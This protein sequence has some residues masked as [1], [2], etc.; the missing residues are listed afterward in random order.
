MT[1]KSLALSTALLAAGSIALALSA[2]L[3][4]SA[5]VTIDDNTAQAGTFTVITFTVPNESATV[6]TS[7]ITVTLPSDTPFP[8]VSYV[9]V[10]GWTTE[11][12]TTT[13]P[14]PVKIGDSTITEAVTSVV[15]TAAPG[16]EITDGQLQLFPLSVGIVP[17]V[18]SVTLPVDQTYSDGTVVSWSENGTEDEVEHP[19]PVL[20]I[21]DA[22]V[23]DDDH[24]SPVVTPVASTASPDVLARV[25]GTAGLVLGAGGIAFGAASRRRAKADS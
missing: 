16:N 23:A 17:D 8:Y 15:W 20:Y 19:A 18:G 9:P 13:L 21:N 1:K 10:P 24:Q 25:L 6:A 14:A 5:H 22:P 12:I 7:K 11:L 4:A 2:P 3:A